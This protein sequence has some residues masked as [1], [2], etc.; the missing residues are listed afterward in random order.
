MNTKTKMFK[1]GN[2]FAI[3]IPKDLLP[4]EIPEE[5]TIEWRNGEWVI[6]PIQKRSLAGLMAKFK[7]FS[8]DFMPNGRE[9]HEQKERDWSGIFD[10]D[11]N[12][13]IKEITADPQ[14]K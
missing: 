3:R 11:S 5:V 13:Q 9:F 10:E 7:A 14:E 12:S 4:P 8:P 1:S 2:S 6:R